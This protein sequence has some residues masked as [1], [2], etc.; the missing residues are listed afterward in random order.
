M[1]NK[2]LQFKLDPTLNWNIAEIISIQPNEIKF[3][4]INKDKKNTKGV[5]FKKE[6]KWTL[7]Q[8]KQ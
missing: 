1:E 3:K 2:I 4:N 7:R 5:L 6:I 8:K